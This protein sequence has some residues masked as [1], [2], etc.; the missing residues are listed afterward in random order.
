MFAIEGLVDRLDSLAQAKTHRLRIHR[1]NQDELPS[2]F[3][4]RFIP[5][6]TPF[7]PDDPRD[8]E[9]LLP[10]SGAWLDRLIRD[11]LA[12]VRRTAR[13]LRRVRKTSRT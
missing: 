8:M 4:S 1:R 10:E 2:P 9:E 13:H 12:M 6:E 3:W 11:P 5:D 7:D